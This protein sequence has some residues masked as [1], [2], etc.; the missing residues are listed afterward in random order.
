MLKS[1]IDW[2]LGALDAGGYWLVAALMALESSIVPLPSE[3]VIPPA[4]HLAVTTGRMSLTGIVIAGTA[5]SWF[6]ATLMYVA[7]RLLGR[8]LILRFGRYV[9][10]T[11]DKV[12]RA[13]AWSAEFGPYGVFASRLLPVIRHL[14]GIPAGIV[15]LHYGWYSLAT[16]AGSAIW[17][18]VLCW[19]GVQAGRDQALLEGDLRHASLWLAGAV[20]A[21]GFLYWLLVHRYMRRPPAG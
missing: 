15:R 17:S 7:A 12:A 8:P 3:V 1:L 20:I 10:V 21:L 5:G 18:A 16:L 11:A 13:E 9:L 14:I 19:I 4:A 2:Y 6:G